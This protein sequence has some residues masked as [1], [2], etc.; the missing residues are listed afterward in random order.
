MPASTTGDSSVA[1]AWK[2]RTLTFS[3]PGGDG[4]DN[5]VDVGSGYGLAVAALPP[6]KDAAMAPAARAAAIPRL[7][8]DR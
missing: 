8:L 6:S 5:V 4:R 7:D 3:P 1:E 2:T